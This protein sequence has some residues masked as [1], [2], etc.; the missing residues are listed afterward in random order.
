[1]LIWYVTKNDIIGKNVYQ[2]DREN[3]RVDEGEREKPLDILSQM[4]YFN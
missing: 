2:N 1:M 3:T 4:Q